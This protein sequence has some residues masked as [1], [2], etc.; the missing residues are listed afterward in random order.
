MKKSELQLRELKQLAAMNG[1][2]LC[3][4]KVV[5]FAKNKD[6]SLHSAFEWSDSK[7]AYEYRIEQARRLIRVSVEVVSYEGEDITVQAFFSCEK[8]RNGCG[9]YKSFSALMLD[10]EG[11]ESVLQT[12]IGELKAFQNRYKRLK[13]L[14]NVFSVIESL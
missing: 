14:S 3:P 1:G 11:R 8:D 4:K 13:E 10:E 5:A 6:T 7:A 2:I 12:A 9:G